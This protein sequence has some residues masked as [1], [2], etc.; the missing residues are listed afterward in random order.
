MFVCACSPPS[1]VDKK[2][3]R[4]GELRRVLEEIV[5]GA[6]CRP[7]SCATVDVPFVPGAPVASSRG[8]RV[9]V[10]DDGMVLSASAR[11]RRRVLAQL[12]HGADGALEPWTPTVRLREDVRALFA[13]I[14]AHRDNVSI[15]NISPVGER[16]LAALGDGIPTELWAGHGSSILDWIAEHAP[17]AQFVVAQHN[18]V[19]RWSVSERC[20][21]VSPD[22][23]VHGPALEEVAACVDR[24][25][26]SVEETVRRW[27]IQ[28]IN[29]SW[30]TG[31]AGID[32]T[33]RRWC[34]GAAP[35][36][37]VTDRLLALERE[38]MRRLSALDNGA[39]GVR[40]EVI[41]VHAGVGNVA[42]PLA[43]GDADH[44]PDCDASM[45]RRLRVGVFSSLRTDLP[46]VSTDLGLL[47]PSA[48]N[49]AACTDLF[50]NV[51][52]ESALPGSPTRD[53][54]L[55]MSTFGLVWSR[56]AW[57]LA[58][59]FVAPVAVSLIHAVERE[60][61]GA[62]TTAELLERVVGGPTRPRL[63]DPLLH[64]EL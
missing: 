36:V 45:A 24:F 50:I 44:A 3:D 47:A 17:E 51:G 7:E 53:P 39:T 34:D 8:R 6:V 58:T 25:A 60:T 35:P 4:F 23:G 30:G 54:A 41:L 9:L 43:D 1:G 64:R 2:D 62:L 40:S 13:A 20:R 57:P 56:H 37:A 19:D 52:Y 22:P 26:R 29:A 46:S 42:R 33:F 38:L 48:R 27:E 59:S 21:L 11:Y 18:V 12:R 16:A 15:E 14:D 55:P 5:D 61:G 63:R 32:E 10:L 31:R 28:S 49:G